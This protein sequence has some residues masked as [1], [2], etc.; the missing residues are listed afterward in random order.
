MK[1]AFLL[2][3]ELN[4]P[5]TYIEDFINILSKSDIEIDIF[6]VSDAGKD[7]KS[8]LMNKIEA[9]NFLILR[10]PLTFLTSESSRAHIRE[11]VMEGNKNLLIIYSF[12]DIDSLEVLNDFMAPLNLRASSLMVYDDNN[13]FESRRIVVFHKANGCFVH[14][15]VF[16]GVEKVVIPQAHHIFITNPSKAMIRGNPTTRTLGTTDMPVAGVEGSDIIVGA[17]NEESSRVVIMDST[18]VNN[19]YIRENT[20]FVKNIIKWIS[21]AV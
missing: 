13:N 10:K 6:N 16:K 12:S 18:L 4:K 19:K 1:K 20:R 5:F 14:P 17:Y 21:E 3:F 8:P 9:S 7:K 15:E 11:A 2:D